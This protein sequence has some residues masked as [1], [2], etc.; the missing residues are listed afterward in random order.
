MLKPIAARIR[1]EPRQ[2][3]LVFSL[4]MVIFALGLLVVGKVYDRYGPKWV[5]FVSTLFISAG[6]VMTSY[7]HSIGQYFFSY[8][9]LAALGVAGTAVLIATLTSKWFDKRRGLAVS[10]SL[11][12]NSMGQFLLV[13]LLSLVAVDYG[14]RASYRLIGSSY[15]RSIC[16]LALFVIKG[17]PSH[18]GLSPLGGKEGT[19]RGQGEEPSGPGFRRIAR[20][21]PEPGHG[22]AVLLAFRGAHV[23][24][25]GR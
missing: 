11:A 1:L 20:A 23:R 17:D 3:S 10:L 13:P 9:V 14:W 22:H 8:G 18:L 7:M 6:F 21:G 4:N 16:L 15:W 5:I 2:S 25:R 24:M 19:G 12:G